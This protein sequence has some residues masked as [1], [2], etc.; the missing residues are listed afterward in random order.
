MA[1]IFSRDLVVSARQRFLVIWGAVP[2]YSPMSSS[3]V[4][5]SDKR[6]RDD[7]CLS[8]PN[9]DGEQHNRRRP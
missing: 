7:D 1:L 6:P 5:R 4:G 2:R 9:H 8:R 3:A